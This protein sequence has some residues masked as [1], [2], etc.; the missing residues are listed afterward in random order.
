MSRFVLQAE[1]VS[2]AFADG[3]KSIQVL[4]GLA[5]RLAAGESSAIVGASGSGKSTLLQ[6]LAG[7]DQT[8]TGSIAVAGQTW[9]HMSAAD[10]A[11]WRNQHLGFVFQF[12]HL[13]AEFDAVENIAL[14]AIMAGLKPALA[15]ARAQ[16]LLQQVGLQDRMQHR[17]A[18]L[19][20]GERQRVAIARS[21]VNE[22]ACVLMDE[23]TGNLDQANAEQVLALLQALQTS[24]NTA[25]VVVTHD[26]Q[27]AAQQDSQWHLRDGILNPGLPVS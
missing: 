7:L 27:L 8:D 14:P 12:H 19:S 4:Q 15:K 13:L 5:F 10:S 3:E 26:A 24:S 22:P 17:P 18:A 25:F 16:Q 23:P 21:L 2:K 11:R 6:L 20:G 1:N 9:A